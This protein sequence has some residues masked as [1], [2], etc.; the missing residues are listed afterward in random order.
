MGP[1]AHLARMT[2]IPILPSLT[3]CPHPL[4]TTELE[5]GQDGGGED[6]SLQSHSTAL[7]WDVL[8]CVGRVPGGGR[9]RM[10]HAWAQVKEEVGE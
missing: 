8:G 9:Q 3:V 7:G 6:Q 4:P 5:A 1:R 2:L 10:A